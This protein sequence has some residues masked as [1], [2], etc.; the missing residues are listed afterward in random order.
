MVWV[1]TDNMGVNMNQFPSV[2]VSIAATSS[3]PPLDIAAIDNDT[4]A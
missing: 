3:T 2:G 4:V 1:T